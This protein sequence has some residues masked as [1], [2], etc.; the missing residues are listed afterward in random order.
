MGC[1]NLPSDEKSLENESFKKYKNIATVEKLE[2]QQTVYIGI[3][4]FMELNYDKFLV[5]NQDNKVAIY[6][7]KTFKPIVI[8][9]LDF[10][11]ANYIIKLKSGNFLFGCDDGK[12]FLFSIDEKNLT[13][14]KLNCFDLEKTITKVI[15]KNEEIIVNTF[16]KIYFI[17]NK[18]NDNQLNIRKVYEDHS[19][20][21]YIYNFFLVDNLL[22]SLAY[23]D[24]YYFGVQYEIIIHD[25]NTDQIVLKKTDAQVVPWNQ[26]ICEVNSNLLA[27]T[28]NQKGIML[29]DIKSLKKIAEIGDLDTFYS[30][31]CLKNKIFCGNG[32]GEIYEFEYKPEINELKFLDKFKIHESTIYSITKTSCGELVTTS[33]D[34]TIKFFKI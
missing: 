17:D 28:G 4:F 2:S 13:Y 19:K 10:W 15:E 5:S 6:D 33:K 22:V 32:D 34:G 23:V 20:E 26:T 3:N 30:I 25:L 1:S 27:I 9:D 14:K 16:K 12:L 21:N 18:F 24:L 11:S 29:Y 31:I 7:K 8:I